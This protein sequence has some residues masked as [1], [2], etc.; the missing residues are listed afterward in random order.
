[1]DW[2]NGIQKAIDYV[3]EH[4]TESIDLE[5][6]AA[7]TFVSSYHFHRVF[8]ILCGLT[9]GEY[10][11]LRRLTLAGVELAEEKTKVIDIALKYGYESPDSFTKA[12]QKFHGI[13]PSQARVESAGLKSFSRLS[14]KISLEGANVMD[15]K[16]EKR[17][18]MTI[19][20]ISKIFDGSPKERDKQQHDFMVNGDTRFVRYALQG[21][22]KDCTVEYAV[23]SD[24][25][26]EQYRFTIGTRIP[27]YYVEHLQ[28]PCGRYA[29]QLD[30]I[31]IPANTY[32][33]METKRSVFCMDEHLE[34]YRQLVEEWLPSS[35]YIFANAPEITIMRSFED[36]KDNCY[37][38]LLIP[39]V[40]SV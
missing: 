15:Y 3:E 36:A 32:V 12:F 10:I 30:I 31:K 28:E 18:E 27:N 7:Q 19:V 26:A 40:K 21:L 11:R 9:L 38:E 34:L 14:V 2:V 24:V 39:I 37:V 8:S 35:G 17:P 1:M 5:T 22:S 13:S 23:I 16:I 25:G 33:C 20:G 29:E 4:L 6:V